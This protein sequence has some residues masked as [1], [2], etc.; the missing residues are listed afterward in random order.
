MAYRTCYL[1]LLSGLLLAFSPAK[2]DAVDTEF[3]V[4]A[5]LIFNFV[6]FT[7][8]PKTA[9]EHKT[10][11]YVICIIGQDPYSAIF[12]LIGRQTIHGRHL[13]TLKLA[14]KPT[15]DTLA[16]CHILFVRLK[17]KTKRRALLS[18]IEHLPVLT[19]GETG[20]KS[21]KSMINFV[22]NNNS[23]AFIINRTAAKR[24]GIDFSSKMLR[25]AQ[26]VT[27]GQP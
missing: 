12:G 17:N 23:I 18:T 15:L 24:A 8:W 21:E 19:I 14:D 20:D 27:G 7:R 16:L 1:I 2:A 10:A 11:D 9:F 26:S 25:L 3:K 13:K 22:N 4:K 6:N 5:G